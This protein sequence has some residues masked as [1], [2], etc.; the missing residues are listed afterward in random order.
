[1]KIW[2]KYNTL[3]KREGIYLFY[4]SLSNSFVEL[5]QNYYNILSNYKYGDEVNLTDKELES[6]LIRM[7]ALVE[8]DDYEIRK[9][10]F[11]NSARRFSQNTLT[12]TINPTFACNFACPYCFEEGHPTN[13]MSDETEENVV[14]FVKGYKPKN[15]SVTWFGGEPLLEFNRIKSLTNKLKAL[16]VGYNASMITNGYLLT[17]EKANEFENLSINRVQITLD[18]VRDSHDCRRFLKGGKPTFD[19]I[20]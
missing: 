1:M 5:S 17:K 13:R 2:S 14:R 6:Y 9:I 10:K 4:N 16:N 7:K 8:D 19:T 3:F 12:L 15:I 18:G 11:I 20:S